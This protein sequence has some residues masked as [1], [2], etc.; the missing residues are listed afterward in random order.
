VNQRHADVLAREL[1]D[2][3]T[4]DEEAAAGADAGAAG[5]EGGSGAGSGAGRAEAEAA[6]L[7]ALE[8]LL[9][10]LGL[11]DRTAVTR[12]V[13][14]D[15]ERA[16]VLLLAGAALFRLWLERPPGEPP[17][18]AVDRAG[19]KSWRVR[20][21]HEGVE[22]EG[23]ESRRGWALVFNGE[24]LTFTSQARPVPDAAERLGRALA[25][26]EGWEIDGHSGEGEARPV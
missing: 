21:V 4:A 15:T 8:S 3:E 18:V 23:E 26:A 5:A 25:A 17:R 20:S 16:F 14:G 12:C 24:L 13:D 1:L 6:V 22:V 2:L 9:P 10:E 11:G 7:A 19:R